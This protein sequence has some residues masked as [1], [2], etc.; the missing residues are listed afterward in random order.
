MKGQAGWCRRQRDA[1]PDGKVPV[2]AAFNYKDTDWE[3]IDSRGKR[4]S[5]GQVLRVYIRIFLESA[6]H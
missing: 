4:D 5:W 2:T 1:L 3:N 6:C